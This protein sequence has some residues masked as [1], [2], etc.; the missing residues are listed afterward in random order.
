M[1]A[2]GRLRRLP[3]ILLLILSGCLTA[4]TLIWPILAPLEWVS[5]VPAGLVL[6][7]DR[8]VGRRRRRGARLWGYGLCWFLPFFGVTYHWFAEMYPLSFT[9]LQPGEAAVVVAAAWGGLSLLHALLMALVF[10]LCGL[11]FRAPICRRWPWLRPVLGAAIWSIAEWTQ[12]LSWIGVPWA[13]L[14]LGQVGWLPVLQTVSI[15]GS[16]LLT[17]LLVF[18]S[19]CLAEALLLPPVAERRI[20]AA[21]LAFGINFAV[22]SG[23][24][25]G[26]EA[27]ARD[28]DR[29]GAAAIQGN[30]SSQ[31]KW[32]SSMLTDTMM[33]YAALTRE[34]SAQGAELV[35][36]P[37]TAIPYT[38]RRYAPMIEFLEAMADD[39]DAA[40][41]VGA[42]SEDEAGAYNTMHTVAPRDGLLPGGY[43]KRHLVPF[44]EYLPMAGF[45]E[46]FIP[47]LA[48]LRM[49]TADIDPG[50]SAAVRDLG[51]VRVGSLICFDSIYETAARDAVRAGANLLTISTNDSWFGDSAAA[52]QHNAQAILRA[53]ETRRSVVRAASTGISSIITPR[54]NVVASLAPFAEGQITAPVELCD[55]MTLYARV[56]DWIIWL[57][58]AACGAV[59]VSWPFCRK[60]HKKTIDNHATV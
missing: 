37:E 26:D 53:V 24:Y 28:R 42:F 60:N 15:G 23:L 4:A 27:A 6:L 13:R 45:F 55:G 33:T 5:L 54:G 34:A 18:V 7:R 59:L 36:W 12:T 10:P 44:G 19:F 48:E 38:L 11:L 32:D 8:A 41:L 56:G 50:R 47:P 16:Y 51:G 52:R 14:A 25:L 17:F 30:I 22:G 2:V 21:L 49:L 29:I 20:M 35:V 40:L 39:V 43:S 58:L 3:M 9:G 31:E 1:T 46:R 57:S